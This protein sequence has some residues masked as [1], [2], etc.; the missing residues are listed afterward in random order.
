MDNNIVFN[1]TICVIGIALLSIHTIN[2][3][4]KKNRRND[5][6]GLL[7]FVIFTAFHFITYLIFTLV[8]FVYTSDAYIM[9]FYTIFYIFNNVELLLLFT[10]TVFCS[11]ASKKIINRAILVNVILFFIFVI[12]DFINIPTHIFFFADGGKYYRT[13]AMI[14]SQIYQFISFLMVLVLTVFGKKTVL[15]EK[16]A[17]AS[18]CLLPIAA[19][20]IQNLLPGYAIGYLSIIIAIEI[21]F[22]FVNVRKNEQLALEEKRSKEAEIRVMMSQIKPHFVYNTLASIS[23]LIKID[24]D[25]AQ[26]GLDDFTEYLR[27]NLSSLTDT[28]LILF[29]Q[30]LKH[31]ETYLSLEKMRFDERLN[32]IYNIEALDFFVPPLSIQ[33]LVENAVKHGILQKVEGGTINISSYE[34]EDAYVIEIKDDGV[35]FNPSELKED[36]NNHIGLNNVRYRLSSMCHGD[37]KID[38]EVGKGT[39]ITVHFYKR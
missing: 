28:G 21:L 29:N 6:N 5:E 10:Y 39:T 22:L 14:T 2:I 1:I 7:V 32:I 37:M 35:G 23:T 31:I 17:F 11:V 36:D 9:A 38:S 25:K 18:Y 26:K 20:V 19:I 3:A 24:P 12:L 34:K 30:E 8:K 15:A 16:L 33:P 13:D 4:L 27:T